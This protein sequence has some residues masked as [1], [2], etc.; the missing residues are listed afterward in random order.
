[1]TIKPAGGPIGA[2][3]ARKPQENQVSTG[4]V[5]SLIARFHV[6]KRPTHSSRNLK[7]RYSVTKGTKRQIEPYYHFSINSY[8]VSPIDFWNLQM[9]L[10]IWPSTYEYSQKPGTST[11]HLEHYPSAGDVLRTNDFTAGRVTFLCSVVAGE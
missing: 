1:M 4:D 7:I 11:R 8:Q 3:P 9:L 6:L 5:V 10:F 2:W